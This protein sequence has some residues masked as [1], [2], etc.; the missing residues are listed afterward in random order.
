MAQQIIVAVHDRALDAFMQPWTVPAIG[1]AIRGFQDAVNNA[2]TPMFKHPDDYDLYQL[3]VFDD[4]T[5]KLI[6]LD[7]PKQ[8]AIG[9]QLKTQ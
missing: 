6:P 5:G 2:E 8:I 7:E 3:G 4:N 1:A 9:K